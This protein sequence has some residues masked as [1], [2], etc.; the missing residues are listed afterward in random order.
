MYDRD[1]LIEALD[2]GPSWSERKVTWD[3]QQRWG[4][5]Q[6]RAVV[7]EFAERELAPS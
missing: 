4:Q 7:R 5:E 6:M 1:E 2:R 3:A